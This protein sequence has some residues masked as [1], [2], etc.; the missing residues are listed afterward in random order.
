M[1]ASEDPSAHTAPSSAWSS[2]VR[3][4]IAIW[5]TTALLPP[6]AMAK[7]LLQK[8]TDIEEFLRETPKLLMYWFFQRRKSFMEQKTMTKWNRDNLDDYILLPATPGSVSRA[9]CFF[10]SHYWHSAE[11]PD[12]GGKYLRLMQHDLR[13]KSWSFVWVDWTCVPQHPRSPEEEAYFTRVLQTM[14]GIIRN[15]GFMYY[16]PPFQPRLWILYE[17]AENFLTSVKHPEETPD[18]KPFAEHV[19]EMVRAGVRPT[20]ERHGYRCTYEGD[21]DFLVSWLELLVLLNKLSIDIVDLRLLVDYLTW[22]PGVKSLIQ[23]TSSGQPVH[24]RRFEG[25]VEYARERHSFTSFPEWVNGKFLT[26]NQSD[27][28]GAKQ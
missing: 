25:G 13:Q 6:Q 26:K 15:S 17:V 22:G 9:E 19:R 16:Y 11:D 2:L 24:V 10:V 1:S 4:S 5:E 3:R 14:S 20:L 8:Y 18:L 12:P 23:V 21:K 7:G 27:K 28:G